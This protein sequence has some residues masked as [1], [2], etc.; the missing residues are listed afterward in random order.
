M[1]LYY[2]WK[3]I[4]NFL[5]KCCELVTDK[6][7]NEKHNLKTDITRVVRSSGVAVISLQLTGLLLK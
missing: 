5:V 4:V 7:K 2:K 6:A 1:I 3:G